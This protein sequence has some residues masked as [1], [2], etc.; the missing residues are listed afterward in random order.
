VSPAE[1]GHYIKR[2]RRGQSPPS[3][4]ASVRLAVG[5]E[6]AFDFPKGFDLD[7]Q[8]LILRFQTT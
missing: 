2:K 4:Y 3:R 7:F 6:R 1:A 8:V 5:V